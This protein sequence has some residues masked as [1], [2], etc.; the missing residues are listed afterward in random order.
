MV[1][2]RSDRDS[3][4]DIPI[5]ERP[6]H[7]DRRPTLVYKEHFSFIKRVQNIAAADRDLPAFD[8]GIL[9][10]AALAIVAE[11]PGAPQRVIDRALQLIVERRR[12]SRTI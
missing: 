12:A 9:A 8:H 7:P 1:S 6:R 2:L 5:R 10:S 11:M 4:N 3:D